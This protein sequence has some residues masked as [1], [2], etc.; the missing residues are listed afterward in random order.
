MRVRADIAEARAQ[1]LFDLGPKRQ[2]GRHRRVA[3]RQILRQRAL[4]DLRGEP[5]LASVLFFDQRALADLGGA[6][7]R[8]TPVHLFDQRSLAHFQTARRPSKHVRTL[9]L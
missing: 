5:R 9:L 7:R 6:R 3:Q 8:L 4:A 2:V 1:K